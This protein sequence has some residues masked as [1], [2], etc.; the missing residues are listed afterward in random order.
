[1]AQDRGT[2]VHMP[3]DAVT[4][5]VGAVIEMIPLPGKGI[6]ALAGMISGG[7]SKGPFPTL[8]KFLRDGGS[9][10]SRINPLASRRGFLSSVIGGGFAL[11]GGLDFLSRLP[12][13][14]A[15]EAKLAPSL[16]KLD[17][18]IEP[19]VRLLEETPRERL[20]EELA[21]RIKTGTSYR[22][23]LT[24]LLLAGVR[25]VQPRPVGF[26]FH[27]VL[28][29]NSAHLASLASP[30]SDR[31]LPIFWAID[32]FKASQLETQKDTGWRM[33]AVDES[34]VPSG[35]KARQAFIDAMEHWDEAAAD[36]A[37][38][39]LARY[40]GRNECFEMFAR[41]GARDFRDIGHK[42]I[43]VANSF[44]TLECVGWHNAEPVLRSLAYALL[45]YDGKNPA[46]ADAAPDR[47]WRRNAELVKKI[48]PNWQDGKTS[49]KGTS[50][51][52]ATLRTAG[53]Q[54]ACET[55]V[56]ALTGGLSPESVW[57][58]LLGGSCELLMR[59]TG[60]VSLHSVT[61]SN[62]LHFAH[63]TSANKETRLM[64]LLQNAAF[65]PSFRQAAGITDKPDKPCG[66]SPIQIRAAGTRRRRGR[67][68]GCLRQRWK[69]P[70]VGG[71]K[72]AGLSRS[73]GPGR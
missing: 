39:G 50:D 20:L 66:P 13:V 40:A 5:S 4:V 52:L 59:K 32:R 63:E 57:D 51:L 29:I 68:G 28:V 67:L 69:G 14:S 12:S 8:P 73:G 64:L 48:N 47:P 43:F 18:G 9:M 16:V 53:D 65:V 10:Q 15:D 42:A 1:M 11:G 58:A 21:G 17:A 7:Y 56:E 23:V 44:R 2:R 38:A 3:L 31:W 41:F 71:E 70:Y 24:A 22:E 60:I 37:V 45:Q 54:Q 25:N 46:D 34:K 30:D 55:V 49:E 33:G 36:A 26:K 6:F 72:G 19:M 61:S 62:A 35:E 27:A